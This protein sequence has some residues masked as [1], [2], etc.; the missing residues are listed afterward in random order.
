MVQLL[1]RQ[2]FILGRTVW[3]G[4]V[5]FSGE[6]CFQGW[7]I[8][9]FTNPYAFTLIPLQGHVPRPLISIFLSPPPERDSIQVL[10]AVSFWKRERYRLSYRGWA[11]TYSIVYYISILGAFSTT[12]GII[13]VR[14]RHLKK[15]PHQ[16]LIQSHG[17]SK[18]ILLHFP[19]RLR[20]V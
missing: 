16:H 10:P 15:Q 5:W 3:F 6:P 7:P 17:K 4:L 11:G 18:K 19:R 2:R 1:A 12:T 8:R 9:Y 13:F 20:R 14:R